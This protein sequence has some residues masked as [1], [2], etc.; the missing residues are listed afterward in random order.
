M[1][2]EKKYMGYTFDS[3]EALS[4]AKK[5]AEAVAYLRNKTDFDNAGQ[6]LSLYNRMIDRKMVNTPIGLDFLKELRAAILKS[7]ITTEDK[8]KALPEINRPRKKP[9][10]KKE[11]PKAD[12]ELVKKLQK[13]NAGLKVALI[14]MIVII[15]GMFIIVLTGKSSPLKAAY[16]EEILDKYSFWEAELTRREKRLDDI[17]YELEEKGITIEK[18][19]EPK[20]GTD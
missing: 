7:Q 2:L 3:E 1:S 16:E 13:Q 8:L 4:E 10:R 11:Q 19:S 18:E 9:A 20:N 14:G 5:E 15:I 17:L 12:R 6:I